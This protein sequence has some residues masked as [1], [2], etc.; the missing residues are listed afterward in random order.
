MKGLIA[1]FTRNGVAA[2]LLMALIIILG[3]HSI[4]KKIPTEVFPDF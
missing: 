4:L 3:L 2:N 1:W